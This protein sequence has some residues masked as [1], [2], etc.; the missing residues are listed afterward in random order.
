ME[1]GAIREIYELP[2]GGRVEVTDETIVPM[3]DVY[4][5]RQLTYTNG[6]CEVVF[7]VRDG[8]PGAVTIKLSAGER[9]I[10]AKDL[11]AIKLDQIREDAFLAVGMIIPDPEGG[12]DAT[13]QV[14]RKTLNRSTSRR[15]IT[16]KFL[17]LVAE[18]YQRAPEGDRIEAVMAA[19]SAKERQAFR[20]IA[21]ARQQ[22]LIR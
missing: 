7:E 22:G 17:N 13:H 2:D 14:V 3:G 19:F 6:T 1:W 9:P 20:Y 10:R 15:K 8:A 12:H 11:V 4:S 21:Q 5:Y 18:T 16:P